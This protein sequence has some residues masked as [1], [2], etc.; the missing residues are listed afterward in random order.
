M[1]GIR[2]EGTGSYLPQ[3]VVTNDEMAG[4]VETSDEWISKRTGIRERRFSQGEPNYVMGARAARRA[5]ENADVDPLDIGAIIGCTVTSD[6]YYPTL[7]CIIQDEI[8]AENAFCWDLNAACSGFIYAMDIAHSYICC[9]KAKK[10]LIVCS[11]I[12]SKVM[13]FT[14]RSTCVLFGDGAAAVVV[15]AS[16]GLFASCLHSEGKNG[17]AILCRSLELRGPFASEADKPEY[18]KY[19]APKDHY[20]RMA[21]SEVY[22]FAV[23]ALPEMLTGACEKAGLDVGALDLIVPHQA[24]LRIIETAADRLKVPMEKMYVN[25]DRFGNTS[26]VSIPLCLD[27]LNRAGSLRRG[28][29]IGLVGFGAGLTCGAVAMEW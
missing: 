9:G 16:D 11:E 14:D 4:M 6:F 20:V 23:K 3:R 15:G 29:R 2:V 12:M 18:H 13:D 8:G 19:D 25:V 22:R 1:S 17:G 26:C 7:A 10:V 27:E 24:N 28:E 5:L 21:G